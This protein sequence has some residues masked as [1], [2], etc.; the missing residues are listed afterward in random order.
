MS[1]KLSHYDRRL[2]RVSATLVLMGVILSF[3]AGTAHP[4]HAAA[5]DH[6]AAFTEYA[7]SS[8]WTAVHLGQFIGMAFLIAGLAVMFF[9]LNLRTNGIGWIGRLGFLCAVIALGLYGVLQ[10]VDGVAL[11]QAVD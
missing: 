3:L 2:L 8:T 5:N 4:D 6:V 11:K 9:G 10:A 1:A 7:N